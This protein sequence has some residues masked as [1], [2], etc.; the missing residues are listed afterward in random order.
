[1]RTHP[2]SPFATARQLQAVLE[3]QNM[4]S[5][6]FGL[7]AAAVFAAQCA[8]IALAVQRVGCDSEKSSAAPDS[9]ACRGEA[10]LAALAVPGVPDYETWDDIIDV[11]SAILSWSIILTS[12]L[13]VM[14]G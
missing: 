2:R 11:V 9:A 14:A 7:A 4:P 13:P 10:F 12:C 3:K 1:M 8:G 5:F 6:F